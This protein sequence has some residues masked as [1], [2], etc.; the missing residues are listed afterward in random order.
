MFNIPD[1]KVTQVKVGEVFHVVKVGHGVAS[2]VG[3]IITVE[4]P[5]DQV[6][7]GERFFATATNKLVRR[8]QLNDVIAQPPKS[9]IVY[10]KPKRVA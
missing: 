2:L 4:V 1:D 6:K 10:Y 9:T 7:L 5:S 3:E 8:M